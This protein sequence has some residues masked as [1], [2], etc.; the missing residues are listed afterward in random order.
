MPCSY[1]AYEDA[2]I[3]VSARSAD[4]TRN[5]PEI[6][7]NP[8][9]KLV[10]KVTNTFSAALVRADLLSDDSGLAEAGA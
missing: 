1:V 3:H 5:R 7:K 2:K 4:M 10:V 6:M 9:R 8:C